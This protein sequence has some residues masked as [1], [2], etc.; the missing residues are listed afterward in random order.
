M[1]ELL[2]IQPYNLVPETHN[3]VYSFCAFIAALADARL[4]A[5][6]SKLAEPLK[7]AVKAFKNELDTVAKRHG[8][9]I[10]QADNAVDN[11][12]MAMNYIIKGQLLHY[13]PQVQAAT[14]KV[15]EIFKSFECPTRLTYKKGYGIYDRLMT[16][17]KALP[18]EVLRDSGM[19]GWVNV[20]EQRI[21]AFLAA[22]QE[23]LNA[24]N[25]VDRASVCKARE[26]LIDAYVYLTMQ[27]NARL[28]LSP[29]ETIQDAVQEWNLYID[30][31]RSLAK[32]A[33]T[34]KKKAAQKAA[35][36]KSDKAEAESTVDVPASALSDDGDDDDFDDEAEE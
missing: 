23:K 33:A 17:L 6:E 15:A 9:T 34:R 20:L 24:Q 5:E 3:A 2:Q 27:L 16:A 1:L 10:R 32:A 18:A 36:S 12:Y 14:A 11:C 25:E 26:A 28:I 8:T 21:Q 19:D 29:S 35:G 4:S 22:Q 30:Q 13:D 7:T 31:Q